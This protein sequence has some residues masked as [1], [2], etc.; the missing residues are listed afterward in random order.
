M[1]FHK[2]LIAIDGSKSAEKVAKSGFELAKQ[3]GS[4][5]ALV[6]IVTESE[7]DYD[8]LPTPREMEDMKGF[9]FNRGQLHV[10]ET[11]FK[12]FPVKTFVEEGKPA[13]VIIKIAELWKADVIVM[14][15]HGRKGFSHLMMGSVAEEVI[16][17]S[18]KTAVVI[19]IF[20]A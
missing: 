13:E 2:I 16:R 10:I 18:K 15:T 19:P 12:D 14:G 5:I 11:V 4:E 6:S 8:N 3:F 7:D 17:G 20:D 1:E 9:N